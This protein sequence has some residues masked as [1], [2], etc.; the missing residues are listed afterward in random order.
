MP[1]FLVTISDPKTGEKKCVRVGGD[2]P[3]SQTEIAELE[4]RLFPSGASRPGSAVG[5]GQTPGQTEARRLLGASASPQALASARSLSPEQVRQRFGQSFT[6]PPPRRPAPTLTPG[7][8]A[9]ARS[10]GQNLLRNAGAVAGSLNPFNRNGVLGTV[11]KVAVGPLNAWLTRG[12]AAHTPDKQQRAYL[13]R[14]A[15]KDA[16][17]PLDLARSLPGALV[18]PDGLVSRA[19]RVLTGSGETTG[20]DLQRLYDE[21]EKARAKVRNLPGRAGVQARYDL[22]NTF[23]ARLDFVKQQGRFE[24]RTVAGKIVPDLVNHAKQNPVTFALDALPVA[25]AGL[26]ALRAARGAGKAAE[27]VASAPSTTAG[28]FSRV[29]PEPGEVLATAAKPGLGTRLKRA[30]AVALDAA[31][32]P[33]AVMA[34]ADLSAPLRQGLVLGVSRPKQAAQAGGA[35]LRSFARESAFED[36][37]A[38]I[39]AHPNVQNGLFKKTGLYLSDGGTPGAGEEMFRSRLAERIP[40]LGKVVKASERAYSAYLNH[41]RASTFNTSA[42]AFERAGIT[43]A[44]HPE[45]F[46]ALAEWVN[47]SSGRGDLGRLEKLAPV[48]SQAM[49]SPRFQASRAALLNPYTYAKLPPAVRKIAMRDMAATVGANVAL[50]SMAHLAGADVETDPRATDFAKIKAGDTRLDF[51]G[52]LGPWVRFAAQMAA[53][54]KITSGGRHK[55]LDGSGKYPE[56]RLSVAAK[57]AESKSAPPV[58]LLIEALR[59]T[60]FDGKP[61]DPKDAALRRALPLLAQDFAA[62]VRANGLAKGTALAAPAVLGAGVQTYEKDDRE[63]SSSEHAPRK[64]RRAA[65]D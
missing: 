1:D 57:F 60:T 20:A 33:R 28:V 62:A 4:G 48:L 8:T 25:G 61:F 3:P 18:P 49:F 13:R 10:F 17:A 22:E 42:E 2:K 26:K 40:V 30:G 52:G 55:A 14:E 41:L 29:H 58:G 36:T 37:M 31:N 63:R 34:S 35:M 54:A 59:G 21:R 39:A 50:L 47:I 46:K 11:G 23:N 7:P 65:M 24:A 53:G 9:P 12:I 15:E 5:S 64:P 16:R 19:A 51:T 38:Q 32:V 27:G 43:P 6:D 44:T 45:E 56:T